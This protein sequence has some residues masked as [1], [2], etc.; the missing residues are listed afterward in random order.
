MKVT[1]VK[2][3]LVNLCEKGQAPGNHAA[4]RCECG[5]TIDMLDYKGNVVNDMMEHVRRKHED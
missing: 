2:V 5:F 1:E 3:S 4:M